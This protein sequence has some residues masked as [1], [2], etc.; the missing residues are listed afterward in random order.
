[1]DW[2][3]FRD[4]IWTFV[5]VVVAVIALIIPIVIFII[6]NRKKQLSYEII[7]KNPLLTTRE[8]IEGK[9]KVFYEE[10]EVE[11]VRFLSIKLINSGNIGIPA[12]DY[13]RPITFILPTDSK[14]LSSEIIS[15]NPDTLTTD[16]TIKENEISIRP[17][18]MNAKDSLTFKVIYSES[19]NGSF[20]VDARIKDIKEIKKLGE[21]SIYG[22]FYLIALFV[23][24]ILGGILIGFD[25][26]KPLAIPGIIGVFLTVLAFILMSVFFVKNRRTL[27]VGFDFLFGE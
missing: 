27:K 23:M 22:T 2:T 24:L 13:E 3:V 6:Q 4:Q 8:K 17:V 10:N 15:T 1:M 16:I 7:S 9:I 20:I 11:N 19:K 12:N 5:G 26:K 18:L 25:D 21:P 14:I